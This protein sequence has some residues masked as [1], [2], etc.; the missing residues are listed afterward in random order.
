MIDLMLNTQG[1]LDLSGNDLRWIDGAARV[2]QQ[3]QIKLQLWQGE[4]F[5]NTAF[6]TPY[7]ERILGKQ[8]TVHG[9]LAAL[10]SSILAVNGV[11]D[12]QQFRYHVNRHTRELAVEFTVTT[13][14]G[15]IE[16]KGN[17]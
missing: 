2:K 7:L 14:Y 9:A 12:I 13:P 17:Q 4:W 5:L 8:I 3:L 15:L 6:G 1:D 11:Q 10:K 16:Y